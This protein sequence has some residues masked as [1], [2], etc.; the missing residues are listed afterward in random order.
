MQSANYANCGQT[1]QTDRIEQGNY[2]NQ[3]DQ[4]NQS[5]QGDPLTMVGEQTNHSHWIGCERGCGVNCQT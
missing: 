5:D 1:D 4:T 3:N 2:T